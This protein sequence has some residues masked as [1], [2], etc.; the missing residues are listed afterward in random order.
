[1]NATS[2]TRVLAAIIV[3]IALTLAGVTPIQAAIPGAPIDLV[4]IQLGATGYPG[5]NIE[6]RW[7]APE[8]GEAPTSYRVYRNGRLINVTPSRITRVSLLN[9]GATY[10][11]A[12]TSVNA[13]G[14]SARARIQVT[15]QMPPSMPLNLQ[16]IPG[17]G[18]VTLSWSPPMDSGGTLIS[19]YDI[20]ASPTTATPCEM[21]GPTTCV[22]TGLR[23]GTSYEFTVAGRNGAYP[24]LNGLESEPAFATPGP[25]PTGPSEFFE[26]SIGSTSVTLRWGVPTDTGGQEITGYQISIFEDRGPNTPRELY[27][28][29]VVSAAPRVATI[30]DLTPGY[31]YYFGIRAVTANGVGAMTENVVVNPI[32]LPAAPERVYI[33][34]VGAG[35]VKVGW[36]EPDPNG[37]ADP[38]E[39]RITARPS[40]G[41]TPVIAV[42]RTSIPYEECS[43]DEIVTGLRNGVTYSFSVA[44]KNTFGYGP[45]STDP[46]TATPKGPAQESNE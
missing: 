33:L 21:T 2:L 24:Q 11:F 20:V 16:A 5:P 43:T 14:E 1:M 23:N 40:D 42:C 12:V 37:G 28:I 4:A 10:N 35:A 22:L 32:G 8:T 34:G 41:G 44:A 27:A 6:L 3:T 29:T 18:A 46:A 15:G 39:Y 38:S 30:E 25:L 7:K 9:K 36:E 26:D 13:D 31:E 45:D 19:S 17:N